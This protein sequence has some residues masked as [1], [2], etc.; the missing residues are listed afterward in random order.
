MLDTLYIAE[1]C[2]LY[3]FILYISLL[4][5]LL[6]IKTFFR[7]VETL[8]YKLTE[9][10]KHIKQLINSILIEHLNRIIFCTFLFYECETELCT[11]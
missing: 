10:T 3:T 4:T 1:L 8:K 5:L 6:L 2:F 11:Y 9:I 7:Q